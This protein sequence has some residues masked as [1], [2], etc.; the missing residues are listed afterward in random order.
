MVFFTLGQVVATPGALALLEKHGKSPA[1]FLARHSSNDWGDA[2]SEDA[3]Q[4]DR[5]AE[6]GYQIMSVYKIAANASVWII[7]EGDR[8]ATTVLLPEDY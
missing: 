6:C 8:S 1:E 3:E 2:C 4:N 7:T 5:A